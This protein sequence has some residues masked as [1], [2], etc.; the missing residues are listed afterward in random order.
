MNIVTDRLYSGNNPGELEVGRANQAIVRIRRDFLKKSNFGVMYLDKYDFDSS[1][2]NRVAAF[3]FNLAFGQSFQSSGFIAKSATPGHTGQDSSVYADCFYNDQ[4]WYLDVS[5][6]DIGSN[7]KSEMGFIPRTD[8]RKFKGNLGLGPR[9]R[10]FNIRQ[11]FLFNQITYIEN[12]AGRL[13]SRVNLTGAFTL[14]Q[15]GSQLFLGLT[16]NYEFLDEDFEIKEDVFI[17]PGGYDFNL[18]VAFFQSD[19][20]KRLALRAETNAGQFYHGRL[21]R[22]NF[23][24]YLKLNRHM[25][26]EFLYDRNHFDLPV[27]GGKFYTNIA[28]GRF[29]YS[30]SPDLFAKAYLQW[31][32]TE[33]L[34]R[35]DFLVRWIYKP[36]ANIFLIYNETRKI[37]NGSQV[38]DRALMLKITFLFNY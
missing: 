6:T 15:N 10:F 20:S 30:F 26:L 18:G 2:S 25:N 29:I 28:A 22:M 8:I 32:S 5:Y 16:Q 12:H 13:D 23:T 27:E 24:G 4:F 3:D 1:H 36:G 19:K 31:N 38:Q 17:P 11:I 37:G 35:A 14:F 34:F 33:D 21:L 9:P 7:F